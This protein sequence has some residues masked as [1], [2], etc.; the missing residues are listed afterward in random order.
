[1][2]NTVQ[3]ILLYLL[4]RRGTTG[5]PLYFPDCSL[6]LIVPAIALTLSGA[7]QLDTHTVLTTKL[8]MATCGGASSGF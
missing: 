2:Y 8:N 1:M 3:I 7:M 4:K 5:D 6:A